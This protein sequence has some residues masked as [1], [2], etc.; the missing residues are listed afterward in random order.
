[1]IEDRDYGGRIPEALSA[2]TMKALALK[3]MDR[4]KNVQT[5]Q[6]DITAYQTGFAT[7]AEN[8]GVLKQMTLLVKR[9]K[10]LFSTAAAAWLIITALA[11]WFVINVTQAKVQA[12][13]E[14]NIAAHERDRAEGAL[15]AL[16]AT[17][18]DMLALA[19]SE[20]AAQ[21]F[22]SALKKTDAALGLDPNLIAAYWR[23]GWVLVAQEKLP[24]AVE[25]LRFAQSKDPANFKFA[26]L[27]PLVEKMSAAPEGERHSTKIVRPIF[28]HLAKAGATGES[29]PFVRFLKQS[30]DENFKLVQQRLEQWLGKPRPGEKSAFDVYAVGGN[31][32]TVYISGIHVGNLDPLGGLPI[33]RLYASACGITSAEPLR[34]IHLDYLDLGNAPLNDISPLTGMKLKTLY[35]NGSNVTDLRPLSGMPLEVL[36]LSFCRATDFSTLRGMPL[37][38]LQISGTQFSDARVLSGMPLSKLIADGCRISDMSALEGLPLKELSLRNPVLPISDCAPLLQAPTLERL[39]IWCDI[40]A[41]LPLRSHPGLKEIY[42]NDKGFRPV[43]DFWRDYDAQ[44]AAQKK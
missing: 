6:K 3:P 36:N 12:E 15:S 13:N 29:T 44:Q 14:R 4:Y 34:G 28:D 27:I 10:A 35:L 19:A 22:E 39:Q 1:V 37:Q 7:S 9:H 40:K 18:P 26:E 2:V 38:E 23:R 41:L 21:R 31:E 42:W 30:K 11:V 24:E 25:A 16:K 32:I 5:L 20:A 43:A 8:A 17:G 33:D